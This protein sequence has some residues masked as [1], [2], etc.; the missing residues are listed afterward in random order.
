VAMELAGKRSG[1]GPTHPSPGAK[2]A[3]P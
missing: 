2:P 3:S 1:A